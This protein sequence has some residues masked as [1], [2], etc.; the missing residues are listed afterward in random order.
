M[1][2]IW[3]FYLVALHWC[4]RLDCHHR[5]TTLKRK[6]YSMTSIHILSR[7]LGPL[8]GSR[9]L[10]TG[11]S[12]PHGGSVLLIFNTSWSLTREVFPSTRS[13]IYIYIHA[14][15]AHIFNFSTHCSYQGGG[16]KSHYK[17]WCYQL[18][19]YRE[20]EWWNLKSDGREFVQFVQYIVIV[21]SIKILKNVMTTEA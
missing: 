13:T 8:R 17:T 18:Y 20:E 9:L 6:C 4:I 14:C 10:H 11:V 1:N 12:T 21:R 2:Y 15:Y 7:C 3:S 19:S 5:F 16:K